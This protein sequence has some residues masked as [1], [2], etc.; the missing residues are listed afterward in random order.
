MVW[1][2]V[3]GVVVLGLLIYRQLRARPL[4]LDSRCDN[5]LRLAAAVSSLTWADDV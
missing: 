1:E 4:S 3:L 2:L 5:Q